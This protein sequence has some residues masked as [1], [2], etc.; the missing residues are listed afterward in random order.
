MS[1][2][3][4]NDILDNRLMTNQFREGVK[5]FVTQDFVIKSID[6]VLWAEGGGKKCDVINR[7]P[8]RN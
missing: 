6:E 7:W 1:I 5:D 8:K 3:F 2:Y 4:F